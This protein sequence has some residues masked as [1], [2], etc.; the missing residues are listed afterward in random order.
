M[1]VNKYDNSLNFKGV[2]NNKFLLKG[3]ESVA[4]H[5]ATFVSATSLAMALAVR[6]IAIAIT[7]SVKKENK[8]Y[9]AANSIAS[10]LIKF[11]IVEAVAL[12]IEKAIN[13]IDKNPDKFL[14]KETIDVLKEKGKTLA[15]SKNYGI[16]TQ[17]IKLSSNLFMSTPKSILT[18]A[19]IPVIMNGLFAKKKDK[20]NINDNRF[21]QLHTKSDSNIFSNMTPSFKGVSTNTTK[22]VSKIIDNKNVQ[23]FVIKHNFNPENVARNMSVITDV[24]LTASS[25]IRTMKSNKIK[26]ERKRP[27]IYNNIISTGLSVLGGCYLDKLAQ[28]GSKNFIAKFTEANK[29][30]PKLAKYIQGLNVVRP[31]LIFAI[32]YY[33]ILPMFSS[34]FA[35]KLDNIQQKHCNKIK[36]Q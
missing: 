13:N 33:G 21:S 34:F 17:L 25:A 2:M 31:T 32:V 27:L 3:L 14:K 12:P 22:L 15:D 8:Q 10:G 11:G 5:P 30:D 20:I 24:V 23:N 6:P 7:P 29:N 36:P 1:R 16:L 28:K 9:A 4:N 26:E 35:E 19:L 18:V